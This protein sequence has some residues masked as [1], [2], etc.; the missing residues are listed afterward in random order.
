[1]AFDYNKIDTRSRR[2]GTLGVRSVIHTLY[3]EHGRKLAESGCTGYHVYEV[4]DKYEQM[5]GV[6]VVEEWVDAQQRPHKKAHEVKTEAAIISSDYRRDSQLE[7]SKYIDDGK[8]HTGTGNTFVEMVQNIKTG[9]DGWYPKMKKS[10]PDIEKRYS[11]GRNIWIVA[12]QPKPK[13]KENGLICDLYKRYEIDDDGNTKELKTE[14]GKEL[15]FQRWEN[16]FL[17]WSIPFN[18]YVEKV[19]KYLLSYLLSSK[20]TI[21]KTEGII[22]PLNRLF[23]NYEYTEEQRP[24]YGKPNEDGSC[25]YLDDQVWGRE[26]KDINESWTD[27]D[28]AP[29]KFKM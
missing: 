13:P 26:Q 21:G 14:D 22:V 5:K 10:Q 29:L 8:D 28:H 6:D 1:M 4:T 17:L 2:I 15:Y 9:D 18:V 27:A 20:K 19:D 25:C 12:Y 3:F 16:G 24:I 7:M 23:C 11:D